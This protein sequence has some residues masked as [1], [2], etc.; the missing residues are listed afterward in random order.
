MRCALCLEERELVNSHIIS[1]FAYRDI[2]NAD[3]HNRMLTIHTTLKEAEVEL[4][5][6]GWKEQ[7]MCRRCDNSYS[8]IERYA[9]GLIYG[10]W[11]DARCTTNHGE[12]FKVEGVD[13]VKFKLFQMVTLWRA[14]SSNLPVFS[15]VRLGPYRE[16]LRRLV[17]AQQPGGQD[18][19][20]CLM[21]SLHDDKEP[22]DYVRRPDWIRLADGIRAYRFIFAGFM[23]LFLVSSHTKKSSLLK[24]C[25]K[26]D[27]T[28][29][30]GRMQASECKF[31][32][33]DAKQLKRVDTRI[34]DLSRRMNLN[35]FTGF[36]PK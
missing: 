27:G 34:R 21:V 20:P 10:G 13:Y 12:Y 18:D 6:D 25:L 15:E 14:A 7:L 9:T 26:H 28:L 32:H 17:L 31:F 24:F 5:Q 29:F 22:V 8:E 33:G 1:K 23:W 3:P 36:G 4:A 2:R 11:N 16:R 30:I 19:F 35:G